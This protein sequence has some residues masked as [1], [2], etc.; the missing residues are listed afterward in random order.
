MKIAENRLPYKVIPNFSNTSACCENRQAIAFG[1]LP[2]GFQHLQIEDLFSFEDISRAGNSLSVR[3]ILKNYRI[4]WN[5]SE[6]AFNYIKKHLKNVLN[7]STGIYYNSPPEIQ[8]KVNLEELQRAAL[9]HDFGK[10][11]MPIMILFNKTST[12]SKTAKWKMDAH[13]EISYEIAKSLGEEK[14]VLGHILNHHQNP[15]GTGYPLQGKDFVFDTA[16]MI[17]S[18]ADKYAA[19]VEGR[20][21]IRKD[22]SPEEA[23][24]I[25][26]T[27]YVGNG[28]INDAVYSGLEKYVDK[29]GLTNIDSYGKAFHFNPI[30]RFSPVLSE[31]NKGA[32]LNLIG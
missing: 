26:K 15:R 1:K 22:I 2:D 23:L 4:K 20:L 32:T 16:D 10:V 19:M 31:C 14:G 13:P 21:Y 18:A 3:K 11:F 8:A 27:K 6:Q 24:K 7:V 29:F 17:L 9:C 12:L 30:K 5:P 25:I 28:D